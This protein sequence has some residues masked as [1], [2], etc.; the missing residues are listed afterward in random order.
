MVTK[1]CALLGNCN[2]HGSMLDLRCADTLESAR[3]Q[4]DTAPIR[5]D[6]YPI[7]ITRFFD[8]KKRK[9]CLILLGYFCDTFWIPE[10]P[11]SMLN[12]LNS[13]G[14]PFEDTQHGRQFMPKQCFCSIERRARESRCTDWNN[15]P[16]K[17]HCQLM[18]VDQVQENKRN[19]PIEACFDLEA[20]F[21]CQYF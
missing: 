21:C 13:K 5:P 11:R 2:Q 14:A 17:S 7:S 18:K 16:G 6:T 9:Y 12:L 19:N 3:I 1:S 15:K 8:F 20:L 4:P 10:T